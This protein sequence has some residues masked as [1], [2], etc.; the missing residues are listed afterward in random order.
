MHL[1]ELRLNPELQ[2]HSFFNSHGQ[3]SPQKKSIKRYF[4][5]SFILLRVKQEVEK[6]ILSSLQLEK[7]KRM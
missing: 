1:S 4:H 3:Y 2:M 7:S 5:M 6:K